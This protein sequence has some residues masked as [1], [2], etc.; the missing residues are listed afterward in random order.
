MKGLI[1]SYN[2]YKVCCTDH[3]IEYGPVGNLIKISEKNYLI[4]ENKKACNFEK[5][6]RFPTK[7]LLIIVPKKEKDE[8]YK[9]DLI[10][11]MDYSNLNSKIFEDP[12]H[13]P[14][15][16]IKM[17]QQCEKEKGEAK[18]VFFISNLERT[19]ELP[20]LKGERPPRTFKYWDFD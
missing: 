16:W 12:K 17:Y 19:K 14:E 8:Y 6:L 5:N 7:E 15:D 13:R 11:V 18:S 20:D 10:L 2:E 1:V 4:F 9:G 3:N